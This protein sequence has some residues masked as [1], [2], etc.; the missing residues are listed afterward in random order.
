MSNHDSGEPR[1][2]LSIVLISVGLIIMGTAVAMWLFRPQGGQALPQL[3]QAAAVPTPAPTE[4]TVI[5]LPETTEELPEHFVS[6]EEYESSGISGEPQRI[7]IPA[8]ALDAPVSSIGLAPLEI[9]GETY[10]QWQ[11]PN[12][13]RAGWHNTSARLGEIGNTVLNGH[14]NIN[15]EVFRDLIDLEEGDEITIFDD[16]TPYTYAVS[17]IE[18]LPER[19]QPLEVRQEN[20]QWILPTEDERLTIITCYPY[21][22]NTHRL[23]VVAEPIATTDTEDD[24]SD[25]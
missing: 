6:A 25:T 13:Y 7:V 20:A 22:D 15:G 16:D 17:E 8:I 19:D 3:L 24:D 9:D 11:V 18:L 14:H 2:P 21:T 10:Y 4:E 1:V 12:E 23:V 5:L